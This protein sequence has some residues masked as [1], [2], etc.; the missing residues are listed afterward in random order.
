MLGAHI[1]NLYT[2]NTDVQFTSYSLRNQRLFKYMIDGGDQIRVTAFSK[3]FTYFTP[4]MK[5]RL[6]KNKIEVGRLNA[7]GDLIPESLL[8]TDLP[9]VLRFG[10]ENGEIITADNFQTKYAQDANFREAYY[11]AKRGRVAGFFD[12]ASDAVYRKLGL[13]RNIFENFRSSG[14]TNAD[15]QNFKDTLSSHLGG[16]DTNINT[17]KN[18][19]D[20]EGNTNTVR[21][22][23]DINTNNL[24]GDTPTSKAQTLARSLAGKVSNA[25]G[26]TCT[27]MRLAMLANITAFA[28][29][30]ANSIRY[31]LGFTEPISKMLYGAA[32]SAINHVLNFFTQTTTSEIP[33]I[34]E[35]GNTTTKAVTGSMLQSNGARLVLGNITPTKEE[36]SAHSLEAITSNAQR[37]IFIQGGATVTCSGIQAISAIVSLV[38][39]GIPGGPLA[40]VVIAMLAET[41]GG[42]AL[43]GIL[44]SVISVIVPTLARTVFSNV[45][46]EYTGIPAGE[47]YSQG[48][49]AANSRV[50]QSA[51]AYTPASTEVIA[52][53]ARATSQI[54]AQEAEIDRLHHSP[55]DASNKNTFL[56]NI[57]TSFLPLLTSSSPATPISTLGNLTSN[58]ISQLLP[59]TFATDTLNTSYTT[60][61][62][63]CA[64]LEE[65]ENIMCDIYGQ[66]IMATDLSTINIPPDDP[67]YEVT[68]MRNMNADATVIKDNSELAKFIT[69]CA[70]KESPHGVVD[71]NILNA[72]QT[73]YGIILNNLPFLNDVV[74]LVNAAEDT[75]NMGWATGELCR[76]TPNNPRWDNEFK[77]YQRFIEDT[78]ILNQMGAFEDTQNPVSAFLEKYYT[79]HPLD[80]SPEGYLARITG[81]TKAD[82]AFLLE[83]INYSNFL[84]N[85]NPSDLYP[86]ITTPEKTPEP[87]FTS[88]SWQQEQGTII[89]A[90]I[91]YSDTRNR[92]YAI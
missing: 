19:I 56:G 39:L 88:N 6:A 57:V 68:I 18:V 34:N 65:D 2:E 51:S 81:Y 80:N 35:A 26:A 47:L 76:N 16:T 67:T 74:Q 13:S 30:T 61:F 21:N 60:T 50:A 17:A 55:F 31:F 49:A 87:S 7:Y 72:L 23:D 43:T 75:A 3:K 33:I 73:D 41:V 66:P 62:G 48:A 91:I 11:K 77:Y 22:G 25:G 1:S 15:T 5:S 54:L 58:A 63:K 45:M 83:F 71:A 69:F 36:T 46:T 70:Q 84:A 86:V 85:Y 64:F 28:T 92:S 78:R 20:D 4:Y 27:A 12:D 14:D 82:I 42:I 38:S 53:N 32:D 24:S 89:S 79:D 9:R 40:K 90:N 29:S 37:T 59:A 44:A 10:G 8:N 52:M